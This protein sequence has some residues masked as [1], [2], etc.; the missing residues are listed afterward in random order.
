MAPKRKKFF[1]S[2]DD[3]DFDQLVPSKEKG[4][5]NPKIVSQVLVDPA[6]KRNYVE[7]LILAMDKR[8]DSVHPTDYT[9][10]IVELRVETHES[11]K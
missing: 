10:Q 7:V 11:V 3:F 8:K 9:M 5:K 6:T 2:P 1:I 4:T